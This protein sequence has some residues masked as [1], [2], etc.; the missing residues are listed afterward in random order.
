M[1]G[2]VVEPKTRG[3]TGVRPFRRGLPRLWLGLM[4]GVRANEPT[5][6]ALAATAILS[7]Y[8]LVFPGVDLAVANIFHDAAQGFAA[9]DEPL[10]KALRKSSTFALAPIL[11]VSLVQI[12]RCSVRKR[13]LAFACARRGWFH[14]GGAGAGT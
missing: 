4:A 11:I 12:V 8:F 3:W 14:A 5:S 1:D 10:L 7:V 9:S 2:S 13:S 6:L